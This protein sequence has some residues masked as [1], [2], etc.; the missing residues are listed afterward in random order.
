MKKALSRIGGGETRLEAA[1]SG[2]EIKR[3]NYFFSQVSGYVTSCP[4]L[5][6]III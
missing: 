1:L 5:D 6:L 4:V 2:G 3:N